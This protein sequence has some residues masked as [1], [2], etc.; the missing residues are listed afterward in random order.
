[1]TAPKLTANEVKVLAVLAYGFE[2]DFG[3]SGFREIARLTRLKRADI[4]R[5]CRSLTRR[6]L[7][8]FARGLCTEDGDFAGSGYCSSAAGRAVADPK[9]VE[10]Y[11]GRRNW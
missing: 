9:L 6:G 5:A 10:R 11:A 2:D 8:V 4:R 1:M 3:Y 7:A